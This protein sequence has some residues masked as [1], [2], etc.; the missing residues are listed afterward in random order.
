MKATTIS[1]GTVRDGWEGFSGGVFGG[2]GGIRA[3]EIAD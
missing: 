2:S 3:I 1:Q